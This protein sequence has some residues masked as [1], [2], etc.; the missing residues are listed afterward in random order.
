M[1]SRLYAS[2]PL[3]GALPIAPYSVP[4]GH[5]YARL[6][7][8]VPPSYS[9]EGILGV[10]PPFIA[11]VPETPTVH[12]GPQQ[13]II[14]SPVSKPASSKKGPTQIAGRSSDDRSSERRRRQEE[15]EEEE[16]RRR[17]RTNF[18]GWQLEELEKAF[19]ASHYPDVFMR[20]ALASR[21]DLVESRVQVWFQN[22]RAKWRKKENTKKGPGRPAHNA[23][24]Q[25]CSG[26]PIPPAE[27]A[28]RDRDRKEKKLRKQL[29]RQA[30]RLQQ[31]Q[32][33]GAIQYSGNS[34]HLEYT[35][36]DVEDTDD[37]GERQPHITEP[38]KD[39]SLEIHK[40]KN[41][42]SIANILASDCSRNK[43]R[44]L[45]AFPAMLRQPAGFLVAQRNEGADRSPTNRRTSLTD[46]CASSCGSSPTSPD[47]D[48][49]MPSPPASNYPLLNPG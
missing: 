26:E 29:E 28:R 6:R 47:R 23:H 22:R 1:D 13:K 10:Q 42:F 17:T 15:E 7:P 35:D 19:E 46:S 31:Q 41:P 37:T 5:H 21:L 30:K 9:I 8:G 44:Q 36:D 20:E 4:L 40:T 12:R 49:E 34:E 38:S 33:I 25:T 2:G 39:Q 16:K 3:V 11:S 14:V 27:I 32:K 43:V 24:P 18:N 48:F 45:H